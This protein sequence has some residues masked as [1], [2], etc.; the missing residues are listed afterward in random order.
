M[1]GKEAQSFFIE[2]GDSLVFRLNT[3]DFDESL[4]YTGIGSKE[5]N[6]LIDLFLENE[7]QEKLFLTY[8]QLPSHVFAKKIDSVKKLKL[9]KLKKFAKKHNTS[10]HF[11]M[12]LKVTFYIKIT[13]AKSFTRLLD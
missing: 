1:T 7:E 12:L 13:T 4:V 9:I 6:Y 5:N 3:L 2:K 10:K 8:S 11:L